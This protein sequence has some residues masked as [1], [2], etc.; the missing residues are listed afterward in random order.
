MTPTPAS[1]RPICPGRPDA[2][3]GTDPEGNRPVGPTCGTRD[4]WLDRRLGYV[5]QAWDR[6][7]IRY[8]VP[9][10]ERHT[11]EGFDRVLRDD[12]EKLLHT[13]DL[14]DALSASA[15]SAPGA[16]PKAMPGSM[17]GSGAGHFVA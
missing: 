17:A 6:A 3:R 5:A 11:F 13:T 15:L 16:G 7:R 2:S 12:I 14:L 4:P 10:V 1:Q 9:A 8:V